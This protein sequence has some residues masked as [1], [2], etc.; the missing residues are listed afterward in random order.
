MDGG[1]GAT[2]FSCNLEGIQSNLNLLDLAQPQLGQ[3]LP[4]QQGQM[5]SAGYH[6]VHLHSKPF[7]WPRTKPYGLVQQ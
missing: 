7:C 6:W 1:S 2:H 5:L 3:L 4:S